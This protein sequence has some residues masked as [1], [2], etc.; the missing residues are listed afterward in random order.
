MEPHKT[1]NKKGKKDLMKI[2]AKHMQIMANA[3]RR[4]LNVAM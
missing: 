3:E 2:L 1:A 4:M